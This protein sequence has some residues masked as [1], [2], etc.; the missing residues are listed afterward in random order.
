[1][2]NDVL[3]PNSSAKTICLPGKNMKNVVNIIRPE[4]ITPNTLIC[5]IAGT[6][7]I[8]NTP[9][10]ET[11]QVLDILYNK[12]KNFKIMLVL[13]PPRYTVRNINK[14]IINFNVRI[15]KFLL[16]RPTQLHTNDSYVS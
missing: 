5:V 3:P 4:K 6:N 9:W 12:C 2:I 1:M 16:P 11:E 8:F 7:D 15:Q 10:N 14:H 13:V